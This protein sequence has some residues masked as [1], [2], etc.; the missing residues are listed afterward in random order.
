MSRVDAL[1]DLGVLLAGFNDQGFLRRDQLRGL[2]RC[3]AGL[4]WPPKGGTCTSR[5]GFGW[6]RC[7]KPV[8]ANDENQS[9]ACTSGRG[10]GLLSIGIA[11]AKV[12]FRCCTM[13]FGHLLAMARM[14]HEHHVSNHYTA[15]PL[16][17]IMSQR[18]FTALGTISANRKEGQRR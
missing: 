14:Y 7:E 11:F 15:T 4:S 17:K 9:P 1:S 6:S 5:S 16:G 3:S 2:A 10:V 8:V 12:S 18:T 13:S